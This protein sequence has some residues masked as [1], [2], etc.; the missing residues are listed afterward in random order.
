MTEESI[1]I[2]ALEKPADERAAFLEE[3]CA[4][5]L[6]LRGRLELLLRAHDN[7]GSFLGSPAA[8]LGATVNATEVGGAVEAR[9]RR[10]GGEVSGIQIGPYRLLEPIGEGGMG[11]VYMA[12]QTAP[13]RR[14]VALKVVKPGMDSRQVLARFEA[15]RQALALMD[16]PN[17]ARVLDAGA[18]EQG[19]P[20][21]VMELVKG[22]PITRFC[23]ERRLTPRERLELFIPVCQAVQHAHQK[24]VIHRDLKPSNVL[25]GLYD[26]VPVPKVIDFGVAKATEQKLTEAT[27][28]TGFGT[29]VG[30]FEYMSP[31]QAQL[32]NVDIDTRS[33]IYS[34]GVLLYELLTGTTPLESRRVREAAVLEALRLV[35][36]EEPPRPSTRLGTLA[37]AA[38][39]VSEAR[40]SDPRKLSRLFRGELDWVVMKA[41]EKDRNRRYETAS[42]FAGDVRRYLADE[43]VLACPPSAAY[44]LRK[45]ARRHRARLAVTAVLGLAVAVSGGSVAGSLGWAARDRAAR[46]AATAAEAEQFLTRAA[47][48]YAEDKLPDALAEAQKARGLMEAGGGSEELRE[49]AGGWVTDLEMAARLEEIRLGRYDQERDTGYADYARV[50]R[51]YGLDVE[52]LSVDAAAARVASSRIKP[53]LTL[54]LDNWA[55]RLRADPHSRDPDAHRRLDAIIRAVGWDSVSRRLRAA[56]DSKNVQALREL[57]ADLDL[58][59]TR[60]RTLAELGNSLSLAGDTEAAIAF[61][62]SA[63]RRHPGEYDLNVNL[64]GQ[65]SRSKS[66]DRAEV[67]AFRRAAVAVRPHSAGARFSLGLALRASGRLDDAVAEYR[68]ALA[69]DPN[70]AGAHVGI[71]NCLVDQKRYGEAAESYREAVRLRPDFASARNGLGNVLYREKK[72]A[73]AIAEYRAALALDPGFATAHHNLGEAL[74]GRNALDQAVA[75][76]RKA[77]ALAPDEARHAAGLANALWKRNDL[78]GA[79]DWG[80]KA[81]AL[82]PNHANA[83]NVVGIALRKQGKPGEAVGWYQKAIALDPN[84][85]DFHHNLGLAFK[86]LNK[87]ADAAAAFRRAIAVDPG[88]VPSH[89]NLGNVLLE[90]GEPG[91]AVAAYRETVRLNPDHVFAHNNLGTVL[92]RQGKVEDAIASFREAIRLKPDHLSAH[93]NLSQALYRQRKLADAIV[94]YRAVARLDPVN[95][96]AHYNLAVVLAEAQDLDG[97]IAAYE[98][99]VRL[100]PDHVNAHNN[101]GNALCARDRNEEAVAALREGIRLS[102]RNADIHNNLGFA[103]AKVGRVEEAI[104]SYEEAI[105]L[106]GDYVQPHSNLARLLAAGPDPRLRDGKRAVELMTTAEKLGGTTAS[107]RWVLGLAHYRAG[108]WKA[109]VAALEDAV[110]LAK[111][112][113]GNS[114]FYLAMAHHRLGDGVKAREWYDKA[115]DWMDRTKPADGEGVLRRSRA[116]AA[117]LL[118]IAEVEVAPPPREAK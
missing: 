49:L 8:G 64:A 96:Q 101:L 48:L 13:V 115:V 94:A 116:E 59:R 70:F 89:Y 12:E 10:T 84:S 21:F 92:V 32:D 98:T 71:G 7:P 65:L 19:R 3:A 42:G 100:K 16:H 86:A 106:K 5:D 79:I 88:H 54:A 46:Q 56:S 45:F 55:I 31:E 111:G 37:Q 40:G 109:S 41:L 34:L 74:Q 47:G 78:A 72:V 66:P 50:F 28:Y 67:V 35:R 110:K 93:K 113:T 52:T 60:P 102:P 23:D 87:P 114:W 118:G 6:A 95:P 27:L 38:T 63:Q 18:T 44:R 77:I 68:E 112:G 90:V 91:D 39:T 1:F 11:T 33:D 36:E 117:K 76:Y 53:D 69:L 2:R 20:Y 29:V 107:S 51:E 14:M 75:H 81:I 73:E 80:M 103:L 61:L 104:A 26:G 25:V 4:G 43:P 17:I 108:D 30:T 99:V 62:R 83:H 105:R 57:A 58:G 22:V 15:E 85:P 9:G 97:A 24:G 82:D